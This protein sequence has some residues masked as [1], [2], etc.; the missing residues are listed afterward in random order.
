MDDDGGHATW[1][2]GRL[3]DEWWRVATW[4]AQTPKIRPTKREHSRLTQHFDKVSFL[5][6]IQCVKSIRQGTLFI[7]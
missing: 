3:Q 2:G 4:N 5:F 1:S 6:K 7:R